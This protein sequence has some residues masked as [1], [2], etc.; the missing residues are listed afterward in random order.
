M[1]FS[2]H[3]PVDAGLAASG[4]F[5]GLEKRPIGRLA[6]I[7]VSGRDEGGD[8]SDAAKIDPSSL[9]ADAVAKLSA[10]IARFADPNMPYAVKRRGGPFTRLYDYDEYEHLA[11]IKEWLTQEAEEEFK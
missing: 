1:F 8:D 3:C 10:L 4:G 7:H 5:E 2:P 11:R 9:A 6:Y